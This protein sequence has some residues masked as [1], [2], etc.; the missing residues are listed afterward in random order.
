MSCYGSL[1]IGR[2]G[3][4]VPLVLSTDGTESHQRELQELKTA[5]QAVVDLVD[6]VEDSSSNMIG[7]L[8][9]AP[10]KI[11]SYLAETSKNYVAQDLGLVKSYWPSA[12]ISLLG[13]GMCAKCDHGQFV[14]YVE[15]AE[16]VADQIVKMIE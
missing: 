2:L 9:N 12:K 8:R 6:P 14:K 13:D 15:E 5:A 10:Q 11:A 4:D 3:V 16:P 1:L 7:R